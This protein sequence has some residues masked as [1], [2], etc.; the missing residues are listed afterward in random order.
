MKLSLKYIITKLLTILPKSKFE[1]K[2]DI[3]F[4]R[5]GD[6]VFNY[7]N[8]FNLARMAQNVYEDE[9]GN[10]IYNNTK[11]ISITEDSLKAFLYSNDDKSINIIAIKGTSTIISNYEDEILNYSSVYNDRFNDNLFFSCCFYE[12]SNMYN[13][14]CK[15]D[16][17]FNKICKK[18]CFEESV[19]YPNNY[20]TIGIKMMNS[21]MK[22]IDLEKSK[23]IITGHSLGGGVATM[24]GI[25]YN[26]TVVTFQTPGEKHYIDL[27]GIKYDESILN[28]IY[29]IG[30]NAD[31]IFTGKCN[32][33]T[34][35]C[36]IGGYKIDTM[37]HIGNVCEYDAINELGINESILTHRLKYVIDNII[38]KWNNTLPECKKR[39]ECKECEGWE[40]N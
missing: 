32:G 36:N 24:L 7:Q 15:Q 22:E 14:T 38:T 30:H 8:I 31:P 23:V 28:N 19:N 1:T 11:D 17:S 12:E 16:M 13:Q 29:H 4:N 34:S 40:F 9:P 39:I 37:C 20:M 3:Q 35:L 27:L 26:K 18:K 21:L 25:I 6:F 10:I 2:T 33:F 5:E